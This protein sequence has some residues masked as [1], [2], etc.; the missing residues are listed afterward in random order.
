MGEGLMNHSINVEVA[1]RLGV[2][3]ALIIANLAYLQHNRQAQGGEKY[4]MEGR[5]WVHHTYESLAAVRP[6]FSVQ[7]IRRIMKSLVDQGVV[8]KCNP[9][10]FKRDCYWSVAPEFT[11]VSESTDA[12]VGIDSSEV[13]ESPL[14][15]HDNNIKQLRKT[16]REMELDLWWDAY[17]RKKGKHRARKLFL[18]LSPPD[19]LACLGDDAASRYKATERKFI[20]QGDTYLS[21][22]KWE[23][24]LDEIAT[25]SVQGWL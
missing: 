21:Q 2:N 7:Q 25:A 19:L 1:K 8:F 23:D 20:P 4:Y 24:E 15:L 5:W 10:H 6:Y 18:N 22:K 13:S 11:H 9:D 12:S 14:V 3:A 17:P 16:T